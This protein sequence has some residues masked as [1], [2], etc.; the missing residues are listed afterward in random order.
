MYS[1]EIQ[2]HGRKQTAYFNEEWEAAHWAEM[3]LDRDPVLKD[4]KGRV[5]PLYAECIDSEC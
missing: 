3:F 4:P 1:V 2:R 5:I